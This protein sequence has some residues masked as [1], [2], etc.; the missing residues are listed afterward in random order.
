VVDV[1]CD[2]K[3]LMDWLNEI[4]FATQRDFIRMYK[5]E[6][7]FPGNIHMLHLICGPEFG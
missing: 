6:N 7:H 5:D 2:K 3:E 1:L 4:G